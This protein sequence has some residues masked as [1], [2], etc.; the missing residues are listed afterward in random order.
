ML[1]LLLLSMI[2]LITLYNNILFLFFNSFILAFP[3]GLFTIYR[4]ILIC[5]KTILSIGIF[6]N[7]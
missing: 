5:G 1:F 2:S 6:F 3:L 4:F 7:E